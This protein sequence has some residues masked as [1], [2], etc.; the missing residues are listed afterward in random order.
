[1]VQTVNADW[2]GFQP[3]M[4]EGIQGMLQQGMSFP[5]AYK[6][7]TELTA[8]QAKSEPEGTSKA[9]IDAKVAAGIKVELDR[10]RAIR[11]GAAEK[12]GRGD[13]EKGKMSPR[14]QFSANYQKAV[15]EGQELDPEF[16]R[17]L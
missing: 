11:A 10:Q 6:K 2:P 17:G 15:V 16:A 1:M 9:D 12:P 4:R 3:G 14:E 7:M 13:A 8:A 5:D